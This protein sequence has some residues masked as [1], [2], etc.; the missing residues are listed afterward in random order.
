MKAVIQIK[1]NGS[2]FNAPDTHLELARILNKIAD[3][4]ERNIIEEVGHECSV[5]DSNGN[6]IGELEIKHELPPLPKL[7]PFPK[8]PPLPKV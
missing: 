3:S 4:V 6:Y 7:P 8:L 2:A 5:A 1:M